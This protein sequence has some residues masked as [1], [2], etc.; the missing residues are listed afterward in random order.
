MTDHD[1]VASTVA[2]WRTAGELGDADAAVA[3]VAD[4]VTLVSPLTARF[5]F[6]GRDQMH[7]LLTA[8][9]HVITK[10]RYHTEVGHDATRALFY[11]GRCGDEDLE[12]AQL[13]R[14]NADGKIAE[15]TIFGRPLPA[16]TEVM[17]RLGPVLLRRQGRSGLARAISAASAPLAA[18]AGA[19]DR[20][21]VPLADP[22]RTP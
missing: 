10:I 8:A 6:H 7:D 2:A 22:N 20:H 16:L 12:E 21:I 17:K 19:G 14:F 15:L 5:R 4:D 18:M 11:H 3:C 1:R 9:F 13:L